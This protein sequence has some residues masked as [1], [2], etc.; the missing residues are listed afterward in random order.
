MLNP[1]DKEK[2]TQQPS[3]HGHRTPSS[4]NNSHQGTRMKQKNPGEL[5]LS[6]TTQMLPIH[7]LHT[8]RQE[9]SWQW[10][11]GLG[12]WLGLLERGDGAGGTVLGGSSKERSEGNLL[13]GPETGL[14]LAAAAKK[15]SQ[16]SPKPGDE[17]TCQAA[18]HCL[19]S[20]N[21]LQATFLAAWPKKAAAFTPKPQGE[22]RSSMCLF[23][24]F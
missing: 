17:Q 19:D 12:Q 22:Q 1:V 20:E 23:P 5:F 2:S 9:L 11:L 21:L 13:P 18:L 24:L 15:M 10:Q 6:K 3:L 4:P 8:I 7:L 14:P 16:N